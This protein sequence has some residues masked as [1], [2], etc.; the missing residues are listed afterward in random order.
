MSPDGA[1]LYGDRRNLREMPPPAENSGDIAP[2]KGAS[3]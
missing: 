2:S 3:R 1:G